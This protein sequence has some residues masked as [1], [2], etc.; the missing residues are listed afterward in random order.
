MWTPEHEGNISSFAEPTS[1]ARLL[2]I[3]VDAQMGLLVDN[4]IPTQ[5]VEELTY[6]IRRADSDPITARNVANTVQFGT[7]RGGHIESLLRLMHSIYAPLF[8]DNTS[9]PDSILFLSL[10]SIVYVLCFILFNLSHSKR[11]RPICC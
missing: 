2:V 4:A 10:Y 11:G 3:Y 1:Q 5:P 7:V 9:W 8:F 6:F